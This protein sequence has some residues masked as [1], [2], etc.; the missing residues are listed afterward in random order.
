MIKYIEGN[1]VTMAKNGEFDIIIHG[2]NIWNTMGAG[3][4]LQ[5]KKAFPEAYEA[6]LKTTKGDPRKIGTYTVGYIDL[7]DDK[8]LAVINAYTQKDFGLSGDMFEYDS[9]R[10][11]L[12]DLIG[13]I[14]DD[15]KIGMPLIGCGLAGGNKE[16]ILDIIKETIGE[17]DVTIVEYRK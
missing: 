15:V 17:L 11:I 10:N 6:D 7:D 2:C 5:I 4:A 3:I 1:L 8:V 16:R 9:F 13:C 12:N 14:R